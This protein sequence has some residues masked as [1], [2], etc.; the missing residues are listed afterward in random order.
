MNIQESNLPISSATLAVSEPLPPYTIPTGD[1]SSARSSKRLVRG[2]ARVLRFLWGMLFVQSVL[3]GVVLIGWTQ[4][5]AQRAALAS[6]RG[7]SSP[8]PDW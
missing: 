4:R 5:L 6:W 8:E 7:R 2:I 3:G 1:A